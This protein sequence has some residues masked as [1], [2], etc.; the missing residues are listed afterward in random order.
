MKA[1]SF[2]LPDQNGKTHKLEDYRG[3]WLVLYFY[4]KDFTSGCTA[5][6]CSYR[7]FISEIRAKGAEVV[8]V[9]MD[10][11]DSHKKFYD[12]Y[13]LNFDILSDDRGLV[14]RDYGIF[15]GLGSVGVAKRT[16]YLIDP[17]GEIVKTYE[18]VDP[19]SDAT[20]ILAD[21]DKA[22]ILK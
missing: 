1:K 17:Q 16:T 18:N 19:S 5:Q 15:A 2:S 12:Q 7:D 20:N 10:S 14:V 4:P 6:A 13:H 3:K 21:L 11:V 8:G 9:S 22:A